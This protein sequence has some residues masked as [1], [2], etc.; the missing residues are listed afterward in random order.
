MTASEKLHDYAN[1]IDKLRS[2]MLFDDEEP[3]ESFGRGDG[4]AQQFF[5]LALAQLEAAERMLKIAAL[6]ITNK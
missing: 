3:M 6:E 5:L 2:D 4:S 1:Q